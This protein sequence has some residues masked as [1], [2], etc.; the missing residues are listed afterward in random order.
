MSVSASFDKKGDRIFALLGQARE[1]LD[2]ESDRN[3]ERIDASA[4]GNLD[5][6]A[7][8]N[9]GDN[10]GCPHLLLNHSR[11]ARPQ[12]MKIEFTFEHLQRQFQVPTAMIE[13]GNL[14]ERE[15][16]RVNDI[17]DVAMQRAID[18]KLHQAHGMSRTVSAV[19]A[20][21]DEGIERASLLIIN[22]NHFKARLFSKARHPK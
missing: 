14:V 7:M 3:L 21:P 16:P 2:K 11:L 1:I 17:G 6:Q 13:I 22:M 20:Q 19:F 9:L 12:K 8:N 10:Q 18:T 4:S 5:L 15:L